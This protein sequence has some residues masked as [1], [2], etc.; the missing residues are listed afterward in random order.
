M[1]LEHGLVNF[2][3]TDS[4]V[5]PLVGDRIYRMTLPQNPVF[6]AL[7]YQGV[8][9]VRDEMLIGGNIS[10][11]ARIQIT[12]CVKN[13]EG[14]SALTKAVKD[15]LRNFYG[16]WTVPGFG[17]NAISGVEIASEVDIYWDVDQ[18]F[19][20]AIDFKITHTEDI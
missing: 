18:T 9:I 5:S 19:T 12:C 2:L 11:D 3:K 15:A 1:A 10:P 7:V 16:I 13:V 17:S 20:T 8:S 14:L 4:G 6:P